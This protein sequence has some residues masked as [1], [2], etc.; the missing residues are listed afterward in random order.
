MPDIVALTISELY[1][2]TILYQFINYNASIINDH[3]DK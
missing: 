2:Q 3:N 1:D